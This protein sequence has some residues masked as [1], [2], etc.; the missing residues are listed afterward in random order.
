VLVLV[1]EHGWTHDE[2]D[3][4]LGEL[5]RSDL[6]IARPAEACPSGSL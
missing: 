2:Y 4:W 3:D 6:R 1:G 5:F